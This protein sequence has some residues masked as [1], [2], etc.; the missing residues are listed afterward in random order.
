MKRNILTLLTILSLTFMGCDDI[1]DRPQLNTPTDDTYWKTEMDARLFANGFYPNYFIGYGVG[2]S[3]S[4]SPLRGYTFSDDVASTGKQSSF[5]NSVPSSRASTSELAVGTYLTQYV[6][7]QWN[8]TWVRRANVF[9]DRL[10]NRMQ[11]NVSDEVY[12]HWHAVAA[13][14]K[15]YSYARLVAVYGDVPY[16]EKDFPNTDKETMFKD[17]DSRVYVMDKVYDM[18]KNEILVNMR[19]NDGVNVLNRYVAAAFASRWMLFEGTW[20]KYHGGDQNVATK[21][22]TLAKEAAEIVINSGLY[23]IQ[24][25]LRDVFGSQDL[26]GNKEALMYRHFDAAQSLTHCVA[27]Y[28]NGKESQAPAPNLALAKSFIC[29]DGKVYQNSEIA[30]AKVLSIG[31]LAKT[32]DPRFEATFIDHVNT[33]SVTLL[34]AA[35]FIDRTALTLENPGANPIYGSSTNTNDAPVIRYAEVLLNWIEAKAELG[36]VTQEDIDKSINQLRRR[37]LDA[38]AISKGLKNTADMQLADITSEFD[39]SRDSDVNPLIWEIRRE[40]RMELVYEHCRLHDIKRW[41]KL[42]Y[43]NNEKYPD[44]MLGPWVNM[45]EEVP[46]YLAK[47]YIG[48]R[49]VKKEDGTIVTFDGTNAKDM[50]GYYIPTNAQPRDAFTD[51]SYCSPIGLQDIQLY[52]DNGGYKLTQTALW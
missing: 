11:G 35:K 49:Q 42:D 3:A 43:M 12:K 32:R 41:K 20:Q 47:D 17:R 14:F 28:S 21:Y 5:E 1:L 44:T 29:Q 40:R 46:S 25:P 18:L 6:G 4:Y 7:P 22:L 31:N 45:E 8:F 34:Y 30:D 13:F 19:T 23:A 26:K 39:P 24:T 36:N 38:T 33:S 37:P 10:E 52:I 51:R 50:V 9:L 27:S 48:K 2:W 16:F 15:C